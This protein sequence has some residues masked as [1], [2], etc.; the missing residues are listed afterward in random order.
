MTEEKKS[1]RERRRRRNIDD[2]PY[3]RKQGAEEGDG[4]K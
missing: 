3:K 4:P 2:K 1:S